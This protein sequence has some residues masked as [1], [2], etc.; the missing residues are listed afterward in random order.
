M[1]REMGRSP[2]QSVGW[3][4]FWMCVAMLL[5]VG[6]DAIAKHLTLRFPVA[7]VIW[8]RFAFHLLFMAPLL[9]RRLPLVSRTRNLRLQVLRGVM[10][11][12]ASGSLVTGLRYIPLAEIN[13]L[14]AASPLIVTA[15]SAPLLKERVGPRQWAGVVVGFLGVLLIVRPGFAAMHPAA[16]VVVLGA[17]FYAISQIAA[18]SLGAVDDPRTTVFYTALVCVAAMS[19]VV[20]FV[21]VPPGPVDWAVMAATGLLSMTGHLA[22]TK[23]FQ[24]APAATVSPFNYSGMVWATLFG[25]LGFGDLP[26][27][28][29]VIGAVVIVASGLYVLRRR[30]IR[31]GTG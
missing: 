10:I 1:N 15:L 3:G 4:V 29:T 27:V 21:W 19:A 31:R 30:R 7:E 23:A 24:M 5:L 6:M 18:R 14:F 20:P 9:A 13:V 17:G 12:L 11:L 26:D 25:F 16:T 2:P 28:W 22:A 8:A